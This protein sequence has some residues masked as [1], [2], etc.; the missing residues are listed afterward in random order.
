[1]HGA[2]TL[3]LWDLCHLAG[4]DSCQVVGARRDPGLPA[5]S[6]I[7]LGLSPLSASF[8]EVELGIRAIAEEVVR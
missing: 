6:G 3:M 8:V 2:G 7:R 1:M 5:A 4:V